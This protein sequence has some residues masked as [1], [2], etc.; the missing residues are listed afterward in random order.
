VKPVRPADV[1]VVLACAQAQQR[2]W[3]GLATAD[4]VAFYLG[5]LG[6]ATTAQQAAA[7][8]SRLTRLDSPPICSRPEGFLPFRE[9]RVTSFGR[10]WVRNALGLRLEGE[11]PHPSEIEGER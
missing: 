6:F 2:G 11:F 7:Y 8:L 10:T 5:L 4:Q 9:Y 3:M 1:T